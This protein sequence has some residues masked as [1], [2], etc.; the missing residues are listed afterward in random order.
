MDLKST[1]KVAG[2]SAIAAWVFYHL[3]NKYLEFSEV[4]KTNIALNIILLIIIFLFCFLMGWLWIKNQKQEVNK[5]TDSK[6]HNNTIS[7]NEVD[8]N[9][10]IGGSST[11]ITKN[12][13]KGNKVKGSMSI[14]G[15]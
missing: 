5:G 14:G 15:K 12:K 4:F 8:E 9:L 11:N 1:L 13:I 7:D 3:I 6:V 2:P 10:S